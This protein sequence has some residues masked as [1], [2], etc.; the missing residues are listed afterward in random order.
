MSVPSSAVAA[1]DTNPRRSYNRR[2]GFPCSTLRL[3]P[4]RETAP[5]LGQ[6]GPHQRGPEAGAPVSGQDAYA[7]LRNVGTDGPVPRGVGREERHPHDP[8]GL[9][10]DRGHEPEF[11]D[12]SVVSR[13]VWI[14]VHLGDRV[15]PHQ[16]RFSQVATRS[17]NPSPAPAHWMRPR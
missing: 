10:R 17:T 8:G 12:R 2:A 16:L 9:V 11:R 13:E 1:G 6:Y 3:R 4:G 14:V 5:R 15:P 7:D